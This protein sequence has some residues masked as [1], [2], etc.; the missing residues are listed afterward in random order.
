[1][2][3]KIILNTNWWDCWFS[4]C[5]CDQLAKQKDL[6]E[7]IA[8]S[9]VL[10]VQMENYKSMSIDILRT[11]MGLNKYCLIIPVSLIDALK[12]YEESVR[13]MFKQQ[14]FDRYNELIEKSEKIF[15]CIREITTKLIR[16]EIK[17][18]DSIGGIPNGGY[19]PSY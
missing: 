18:S 15:E 5:N 10:K 13:E 2:G 8:E 16:R 11:T 7:E 3:D 4:N 12:S 9:D 6:R 17:I 14:K 19:L 1:M